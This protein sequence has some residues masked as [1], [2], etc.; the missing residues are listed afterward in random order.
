MSFQ[1]NKN[2]MYM[3]PANFGPCA[4]PRRREDGKRF[5]GDGPI[6]SNRY[7]AVAALE[8]PEQVEALLPEGMSL[9]APFMIVGIDYLTEIPWLGKKQ[10]ALLIVNF[11]VCLRSDEGPMYGQFMS[12]IWENHVDPIITGREQLGFA[13][14]FCEISDPVVD[15]SKVTITASEYGNKFFE[16]T[17]DSSKIP[18]NPVVF[19]AVMKSKSDG[20]FHYK[21]MT[22]S[23]AP[24]SGTDA[25][26]IVLT[27]AEFDIPSGYE[28]Q[29]MNEMKI[30]PGYG[31]FKINALSWA[32][33]PAHH[34][35]IQALSEIKLRG[36]IGGVHMKSESVND[37]FNQRIVKKY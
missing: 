29:P 14:V 21:H 9:I 1:K 37:I 5:I 35:K 16:L 26:Y 19:D 23:A 22:H 28:V 32:E 20:M 11:P 24:Y 3:M 17:F 4:S 10:Y 15:G 25:D 34:H 12:A 30:T 8:D 2:E 7:L 13:K 27:P 18:Q 36:C 6:K 31:D 33:S